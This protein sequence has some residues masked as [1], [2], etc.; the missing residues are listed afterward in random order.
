MKKDEA[1]TAAAIVILLFTSLIDWNLYSW[2][3]LLSIV[4]ILIAWYSRK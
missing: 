4:L 2:L 1:I 3:V